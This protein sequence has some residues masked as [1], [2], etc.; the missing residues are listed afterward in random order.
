MCQVCNNK[1]LNQSIWIHDFIARLQV[2]E[3]GKVRLE[4]YL[5]QDSA[6][7]LTPR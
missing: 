7:L 5:C 2:N 4:M 1:Y 3:D 6:Y